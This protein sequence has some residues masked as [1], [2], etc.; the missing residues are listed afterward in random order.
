MSD[1]ICPACRAENEDDA[2]FCDQCGQ[3][4]APQDGGRDQTPDGGCP[5]CGGPVEE[6][7]GGT[8]R[9]RACGLEL[10]E[11][12]A[13]DEE[14]DDPHGLP[15]E[16]AMAAA[17]RAGLERGLDVERAV[18]EA[19][20]R[21][22]RGLPTAQ[23]RAARAPEPSPAV[24]RACPV[25]GE[26]VEGGAA[27]CPAC[28]VWFSESHAP[29]PCPNCGER[30]G[31]SRCACGAALTVAAAAAALDKTAR[32]LCRT[33]KQPYVL[34]REACADC[35]GPLVPADRLRAAA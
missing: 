7:D 13:E 25:C 18:A 23:D 30:A 15:V 28:A 19:C 32:F 17:V 5:A 4:L 29:G 33:C 14:D 16:Q 22:L 20:R 21:V 8:G 3:P 34:A 12:P 35:G 1:H 24:S 31:G 26:A 11:T 27:R 6:L 10:V 2:R 9:C